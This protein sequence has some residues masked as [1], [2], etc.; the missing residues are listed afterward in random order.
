MPVQGVP[1][2]SYGA[3][4]APSRPPGVEMARKRVTPDGGLLDEYGADG[5]ALVGSTGDGEEEDVP[6][7]RPG[8]L[9]ALVGN[10]DNI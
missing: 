7:E 1:D 4:H 5:L 3:R 6:P 8:V 10:R 9:G 2:A